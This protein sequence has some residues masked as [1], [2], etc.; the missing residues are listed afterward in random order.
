MIN[1]Y[2]HYL[3][4]GY[5]F[6]NKTISVNLNKFEK[7]DVNKLLIIGIS[8]SGKSSLGEYLSKKYNVDF[9]S[10]EYK[11]LEEALTNS[12]RMV[13]E[14]NELLEL[15]KNKFYKQ[16][17]LNQ[18]MIIIGL[19][20]L[21]SGIRADNRDGLVLGKVKKLKDWHLFIRKN[22]LYFQKDLNTLRKDIMNLKNVKI[23]KYII[24]KF[25][26]VYY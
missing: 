17:I 23:E 21:K 20:A 12:K 14:G 15:Y 2:L 6:S 8:G 7:N 24:P 22:F 3:Q 26:S 4:E 10:D 13:I 9:F 11:G 5:I 19:S 1:S 18:A 16:I 25:K